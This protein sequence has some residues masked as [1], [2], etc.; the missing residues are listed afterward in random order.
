M[1]RKAVSGLCFQKENQTHPNRARLQVGKV[2][3]EEEDLGV[4]RL[5]SVLGEEGNMNR[6]QSP[7]GKGKFKL[8]LKP[9][10][11]Y[12]KICGSSNTKSTDHCVEKVPFCLNQMMLR[13]IE[14]MMYVT[15]VPGKKRTLGYISCKD[16]KSRITLVIVER[17]TNIVDPKS[18]YSM[19][20]AIFS[21][22]TPIPS[23]PLSL[24]LHHL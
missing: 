3:S 22:L 13:F 8:T 19:S 15:N 23:P 16:G 21:P 24:S 17:E 1:S 18:N 20:Q 6:E 4:L 14:P 10:S 7:Q 12:K 9:Q 11:S 5:R 2:A